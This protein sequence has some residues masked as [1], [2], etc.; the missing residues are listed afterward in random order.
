LYKDGEEHTQPDYDIRKT[1]DGGY[2]LHTISSFTQY[3]NEMT[4]KGESNFNEE[5]NKY[6][7]LVSINI[8]E[9]LLPT[10]EDTLR[11]LR[12]SKHTQFDH[13][14][15]TDYN[16]KTLADNLMQDMFT[17]SDLFAGFIVHYKITNIEQLSPYSIRANLDDYICF[18]NSLKSNDEFTSRFDW[19][20]QVSSIQL[21]DDDAYKQ[22]SKMIKMMREYIINANIITTFLFRLLLYNNT[23]S[24]Y[25]FYSSTVDKDNKESSLFILETLHP[26]WNHAWM[27]TSRSSSDNLLM[28]IPTSDEEQQDKHIDINHTF[29]EE[30]DKKNDFDCL[31]IDEEFYDGSTDQEWSVGSTCSNLDPTKVS[32]C[33]EKRKRESTPTNELKPDDMISVFSELVDA[34]PKNKLSRKTKNKDL[35]FKSAKLLISNGKTT[36][37][38]T[39]NENGSSTILKIVGTFFVE[40]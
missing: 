24:F 11:F 19:R 28:V 1:Y 18:S 9:K 13:Q 27:K 23:L 6:D 3:V 20:Y 5:C 30:E 17:G 2:L 35:F 32:E 4:V 14:H 8:K 26:K 37:K 38:H 34:R 29:I 21:N 33:E 10:V 7:K 39:Q 22:Q 15:I 25:F 31:N 12:T 36:I 40:P 16:R